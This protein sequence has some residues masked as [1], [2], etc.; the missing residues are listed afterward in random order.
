[1]LTTLPSYYIS[2]PDFTP[3][4]VFQEKSL[5][6]DDFINGMTACIYDRRHIFIFDF[7]ELD[8]Y[9]NMDFET[10]KKL[11][12]EFN[13]DYLSKVNNLVID[14]LPEIEHKIE[15]YSYYLEMKKYGKK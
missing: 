2:C 8:E 11:M 10:Y 3:K 14:V 4:F 7:I 1:M 12:L 6:S 13:S 5:Y 9:L 15:M